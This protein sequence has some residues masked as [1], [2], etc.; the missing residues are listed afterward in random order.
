MSQEKLA[1]EAGIDRTYVSL[2]ER[3]E[4]SA[5]LRTID[6]LAKALNVDPYKLLMPVS[7]EEGS[8]AR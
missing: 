1:H 4:Y 5:S 2:L 8:E 3:C 7:S 6:S